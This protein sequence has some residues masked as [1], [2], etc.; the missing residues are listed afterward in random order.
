MLLW[1]RKT[2]FWSRLVKICWIVFSFVF[3]LKRKLSCFW[4]RLSKRFWIVFSFDGRMRVWTGLKERKAS[5][6]F[7]ETFLGTLVFEPVTL[8]G[9]IE[10]V[11]DE[12]NFGKCGK[13]WWDFANVS[14]KL[15]GFLK[16]Y[17]RFEKFWDSICNKIV[18]VNQKFWETSKSL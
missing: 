14:G 4:T 12:R 3:F 6:F 10:L 8:L 2:Y 16:K 9:P 17:E 11:L 18:I 1:L 5:I 15:G 7:T 13:T